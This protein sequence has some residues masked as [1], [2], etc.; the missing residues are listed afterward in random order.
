VGAYTQKNGQTASSD[1]AEVSAVVPAAELGVATRPLG[2]VAHH[3][4][5][6]S[7]A[8]HPVGF[9]GMVVAA[10]VLAASA[11]DLLADPATVAAVKEDF[12]KATEGKPYLSP[13]SADAKPQ[14]SR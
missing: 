7:C 9:K 6:T 10:K 4:A 1:L 12:R 2:T 13:L 8:A 5:Q 3:W 14:V 11:V